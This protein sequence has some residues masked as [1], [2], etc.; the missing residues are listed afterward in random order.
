M[1]D[2][3]ITVIKTKKKK[4]FTQSIQDSHLGEERRGVIRENDKKRVQNTNQ[5]KQT[6]YHKNRMKCNL[7]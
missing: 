4:L 7:S 5:D 1:S 3:M 6:L 2:L